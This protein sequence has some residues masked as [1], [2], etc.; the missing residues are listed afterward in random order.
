LKNSL[1]KIALKNRRARM[2]YKRS[3]LISYTFLVTH[4][5]RFV[6][7]RDFFNTGT[8][9]SSTPERPPRRELFFAQSGLRFPIAAPCRVAAHLRSLPAA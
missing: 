2:P 7:K 1:A 9:R 5:G 4:F 3:S 6:G 8:G